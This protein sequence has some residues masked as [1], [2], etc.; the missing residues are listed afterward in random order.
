M[1]STET[2]K[3]FV[4]RVTTDPD[5]PSIVLFRNSQIDFMKRHCGKT[6]KE[7]PIHVDTTYNLTNGYAVDCTLRAVDFEGHPLILGPIII[8]KR[9][10]ECDL[11]VLWLT[12]IKA[13]PK[14][15]DINLV[16]ATDGDESIVNSIRNTFH[17]VTLFRCRLHVLKMGGTVQFN[18]SVI[19]RSFQQQ[20]QAETV[21]ELLEVNECNYSDWR[22]SVCKCSITTR[23][24]EN[25]IKY[26]QRSIYPVL[27]SNI[28]QITQ[29][30]GTLYTLFDNNPSESVYAVVK[31]WCGNQLRK[32]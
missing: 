13:N 32:P 14:L 8:T 1:L 29:A 18:N 27:R 20:I 23:T 6:S 24:T 15:R 7:S 10:R 2:D 16:V 17:S 4:G 19:T 21:Q 22:K 11:T 28:I 31:G 12:I 26:F 5:S 25:L 30:A 3:C 9:Q